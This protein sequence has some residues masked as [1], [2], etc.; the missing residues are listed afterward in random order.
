MEPAEETSA[1]WIHGIIWHA[2]V[3][4]LRPDDRVILR[5]EPELDD[6]A[7]LRNRDR[8]WMKLM[9]ALADSDGMGTRIGT[10]SGEARE[11]KPENNAPPHDQVSGVDTR[12]QSQTCRLD[13]A[14]T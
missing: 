8:L 6:I 3:F 4:I 2:R 12:T 11:E 1:P 5:I 14:K 13:F 7:H 10:G 9:V